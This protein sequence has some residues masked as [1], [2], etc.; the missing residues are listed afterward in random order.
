MLRTTQKP[1]Q[2]PVSRG[3]FRLSLKGMVLGFAALLVV[4]A[5]SGLVFV[6]H[7]ATREA[8]T[9]S[10]NGQG[11]LLENALEGR[12]RLLARDQLSLARWDRAVEKI[13][14]A[15]DPKFVT[16]ELVDSLWFDFGH[17]SVLLIGPGRTVLARSE[18]DKVDFAETPLPNGSA[19][20]RIA[21]R[22]AS[23]FAGN[24][25][26]IEGG[27]GQ[28]AVPISR[29]SEIATSA[30]VKIGDMPYLASA[31]AIV[32]DDGEVA[33]KS[34]EPVIL[35]S[36]K[37][38]DKAFMDQLNANL[39]FKKLALIPGE[40]AEGTLS[41]QVDGIEGQRLG[42]IVWTGATP[43]AR[44][45]QMAVPVIGFVCTMLAL[46]GYL[47]AVQMGRLSGRLEESERI[48]R[49]LAA[50]DELT[51]LA[52]RLQFHTA[53]DEALANV[54]DHAP[55]GSAPPPFALMA[56]DL[57]RFKTVN[58]TYGHAGGDT[59]IRTVAERLSATV[60]KAGLVGRIGGDEFVI[61]VTEFSDRPRLTVLAG[62]VID[63]VSA[64]I[65]LEGGQQTDVGISIGIAVAPDAGSGREPLMA[66]ADTALY[67]AKDRGRGVAVFHR[68]LNRRPAGPVAPAR[69]AGETGGEAGKAGKVA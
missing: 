3:P 55:D 45:W 38:M 68:D 65:T 15:L 60:G 33:L 54:S 5:G 36:L 51:G 26:R 32:P 58:D 69:E 52:N 62:Q 20:A 63:A 4:M 28:R 59:V 25:T 23:R 43:G 56:C 9:L 21:T 19:L 42:A 66:A 18:R 17:D 49:H 12:F 10:A 53:L 61:L 47:V 7:I 16:E 35:I 6:G 29:I 64:P 2:E 24:R 40:P 13:A 34:P 8:D 41:R 27:F 1:A 48:N 50:H 46:F 22:A 37:A 31:M 11:R 57:D 30:Y 14:N 67:E 39:G 44:I